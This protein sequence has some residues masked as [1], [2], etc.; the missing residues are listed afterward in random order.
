MPD[1]KK[2]LE[3]FGSHFLFE[4]SVGLMHNAIV[5]G[6]RSYLHSIKPEDIKSMIKKGE[7]PP[8]KHLNFS[9]VVDNAEYIETITEV[10]LFDVLAEARP[11]LAQA[12]QDMG[13][14]GAEYIAKLR[15]HLFDLVKHPE[16]AM[17]ESTDYTPKKEMVLA[18]C[19]HCH[20]S[21]PVPKDEASSIDKCPFCG[22]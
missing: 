2:R 5:K 12:I 1:I 20:K 17:G 10:R 13:M 3:R 18:T 9:A 16:K 14:P 8:L 21:F 4:F 15:L 11:D 6:F 22:E 7:F 19:D